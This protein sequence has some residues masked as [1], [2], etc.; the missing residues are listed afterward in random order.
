MIGPY[1]QADTNKFY[2]FQDYLLNMDT[3]VGGT[4]SMIL[5][6]GVKE[7][8]KARMA[9][10]DNYTGITGAPQITD[11]NHL[12]LVS[13]KG[14]ETWITATVS[15]AAVV[16]LESRNNSRDVFTVV[17]MYDD[18]NHHDG[19]AG[20]GIY[21]AQVFP[22]GNVFS[23]YIY[24]E[25]DS[26][27]TFSPPRAEYEF[28]SFQTLITSGDVSINELQSDETTAIS[29]NTAG[30]LELCNKTTED[31]DL[32]GMYLTD[33][34]G[35]PFKWAFPDT[36]IRSKSYLLALS[37]HA[38]SAGGMTTS[39]LFPA[40]GGK[41][42]FINP[43]GNSTDTLSWG[44][45]IP[46]KSFGRYPNGSGPFTYM[47]PSASAF[48]YIGTT[49]ETGMLVYPDPATDRIY[50]ELSNTV[51]P[52]QLMVYGVNGKMAISQQVS[53]PRGIPSSVSLTVDVSSLSSGIYFLKIICRDGILKAKFIVT[54]S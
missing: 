6:P 35:V 7:L 49:P 20:D 52:Q 44:T 39:L 40:A 12:P 29:G 37:A 18:G 8:M 45:Q 16:T 11:V 25:N 30:W 53:L 22:S 33:D 42:Y 5:Y 38:A 14:M 23:F 17:A 3:T 9:Y 43:A 36:I 24:A 54:K 19:V 2:S 28:Y 48:N 1:V 47:E 41:L 26:A 4:G 46:G 34:P 21:G 51:V 31:L 10:L 27:G 50:I 32:Q 13:E 15:N